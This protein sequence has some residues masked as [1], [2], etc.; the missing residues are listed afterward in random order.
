MYFR[1][2]HICSRI[3]GTRAPSALGN[4]PGSEAR[5]IHLRPQICADCASRPIRLKLTHCRYPL[6]QSRNATHGIGD[7]GDASSNSPATRWVDSVSNPIEAYPTPPAQTQLIR[8]SVLKTPLIGAQAAQ[9]TRIAFGEISKRRMPLEFRCVLPVIV[10]VQT[11]LFDAHSAS[12]EILGCPAPYCRAFSRS[13][14]SSG[15]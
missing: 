10:I 14:Y 3:K 12:A 4:S 15:F 13:S 6:Y 7:F 2:I 1:L 11:L 9:Y 8:V 5:P